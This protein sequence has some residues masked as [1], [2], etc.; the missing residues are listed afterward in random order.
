MEP[1]PPS[2][3]PN[4][5]PVRAPR[6][7]ILVALRLAFGAL[8]PPRHLWRVSGSLLLLIASLWVLAWGWGRLDPELALSV[9][10]RHR[11]G[12]LTSVW[13]VSDQDPEAWLGG[14]PVLDP[15]G[16]PFVR[17]R[18]IYL[19]GSINYGPPGTTT[20]TTFLPAHTVHSKG[21]NGVDDRSGGDDLSLL[22]PSEWGPSHY[23]YV[24]LLGLR[25]LSVF[26]ICLA[27]FLPHTLTVPRLKRAQEITLGLV[28]S[29]LI[30]LPGAAYLHQQIWD[31][32][33]PATAK[34]PSLVVSPEVAVGMALLG[35]FALQAVGIF[36]FR[37]RYAL[38]AD[39][40][41]PASCEASTAQEGAA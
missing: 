22:E 4:P 12:S 10:H 16:E 40:S 19:G 5:Q 20:P 28:L 41:D 26:W 23:G 35:V 11:P 27:L 8:V 34:I 21:P 39:S 1:T 25:S 24:A 15:W 6:P 36:Q 13:A 18:W 33:E 14:E 9:E 17:M 37:K 3:E 7:G 30:L 31:L 29:L 2:P 32:V 38:L